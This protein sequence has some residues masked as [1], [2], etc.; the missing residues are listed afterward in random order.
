MSNP[1][2]IQIAI[3]THIPD[4]QIHK[5]PRIA[6][7]TYHYLKH[8][9]KVDYPIT[10]VCNTE[11]DKSRLEVFG[12][13]GIDILG[14]L[15]NANIVVSGYEGLN[16]NRNYVR[17]NLFPHGTKV[18]MMDDD[19]DYIS[20]VLEATHDE[21][22]KMEEIITKSRFEFHMERIFTYMTNT[23]INSG[24]KIRFCGT[25]AVSN[26]FYISDNEF[27]SNLL[28]C[29]GPLQFLEIDNSEVIMFKGIEELEDSLWT[30]I[31][32]VRHRGE[33]LRANWIVPKTKWYDPKGGMS[34]SEE[35][36]EERRANAEKNAQLICQGNR[37]GLCAIK[38][39]KVRGKPFANLRMKHHNQFDTY[40]AETTEQLLN[41]Y[42]SDLK[43]KG[44][45]EWHMAS[46]MPAHMLVNQ[47]P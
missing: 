45:M 41:H 9:L 34:G 46:N 42:F 28:F 1:M 26:A 43:E 36:F 27:S 47:A 21:P 18:I 16:G 40:P 14:S 22:R 15:T 13:G 8:I 11:E 29:A 7:K 24:R 39:K 30:M 6:E 37:K 35:K 12:Q 31:E 25:S 19:V 17:N 2:N 4:G 23:S 33:G 3:L 20:E 10:I 44:K 38:S 32:Y 5:P